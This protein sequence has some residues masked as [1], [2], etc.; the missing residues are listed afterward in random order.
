[1]Q[2]NNIGCIIKL[3]RDGRHLSV[4][5]VSN[6]GPFPFGVPLNISVAQYI[7]T[8]DH[9]VMTMIEDKYVVGLLGFQADLPRAPDGQE[10]RWVGGVSL[11]PWMGDLYYHVSTLFIRDVDEILVGQWELDVGGWVTGISGVITGRQYWL[12]EVPALTREVI[13]N[14]DEIVIV[15]KRKEYKPDRAMR[16]KV[17]RGELWQTGKFSESPM[18]K[19]RN[20]LN[21]HK[22]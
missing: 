21:R 13:L 12:V 15:R 5:V 1:M 3:K 10:I 4:H 18:Y 2:T 20:D 19:L 9:L 16:P 17:A 8:T 11:Q 22:K 14:M 7:G 6:P